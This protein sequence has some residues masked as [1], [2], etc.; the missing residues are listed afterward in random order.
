MTRRWLIVMGVTFLLGAC[1]SMSQSSG[2]TTVAKLPGACLKWIH[3]AEAEFHRKG[4][5]L[6]N[7]TVSVIER[8]DV[9]TV[10]LKGV[11][12]PDGSKGSAGSH[13][14]YEV[15]LTKKDSKVTRSNYLR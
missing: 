1:I 4:L 3:A 5:N 15:E 8:D 10:I 12:A 11:D 13:I 14:G 2:P 7:Y 9:V 6:D